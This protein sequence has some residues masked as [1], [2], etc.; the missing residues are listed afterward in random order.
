MAFDKLP[1]GFSEGGIVEE[2]S[3]ANGSWVKWDTGL[4]VQTGLH[5]VTEDVSSVYGSVFRRFLSGA[6]GVTFPQSFSSDAEYFN[7]EPQA[8]TNLSNIWTSAR[9]A[10]TT[11]GAF[12]VWS[13]VSLSSSSYTF[14][15]IAIGRWK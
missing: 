11:G 6:T 9:D 8:G 15:W 3:N 2:G 14:Q 10:S 4:M 7:I 5:T 1:L 13:G 12:V